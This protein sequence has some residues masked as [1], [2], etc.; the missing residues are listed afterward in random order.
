V[1]EKKIPTKNEKIFFQKKTSSRLPVKVVS[2]FFW[3][4][5]KWTPDYTKVNKDNSA[6]NKSCARF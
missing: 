3:I 1:S 4:I 2:V 5:P 6:T